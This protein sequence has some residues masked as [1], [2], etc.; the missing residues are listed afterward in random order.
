MILGLDLKAKKFMFE[1]FDM[2]NFRFKQFIDLNI[3]KELKKDIIDILELLYN[4]KFQKQTVF[5]ILK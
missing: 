4:L 1:K 2:K 5:S 3:K